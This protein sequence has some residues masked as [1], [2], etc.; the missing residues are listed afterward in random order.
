MRTPA[1][2]LSL[3]ISTGHLVAGQI[4]KEPLR[5]DDAE[6]GEKLE[7]QRLS[8]VLKGRKECFFEP[9]EGFL[10]IR[11]DGTD[12]DV[13]QRSRLVALL[14]WGGANRKVSH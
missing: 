7:S 4:F 5:S 8:S 9:E 14:A 2:G 1:E 12:V 6:R 13:R 11:I 3:Y 10:S